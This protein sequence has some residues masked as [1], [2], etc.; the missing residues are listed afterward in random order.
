MLQCNNVPEYGHHSRFNCWLTSDDLY[1]GS[2]RKRI[3][4]VTSHNFRISSTLILKPGNNNLC[5][6]PQLS[7]LFVELEAK[8]VWYMARLVAKNG[9]HSRHVL[10]CN[11]TMCPNMDAIVDTCYDAIG[12][13]ARIWTQFG[14]PI[15]WFKQKENVHFTSHNFCNSSTLILKPWNDNLCDRNCQ[16]CMQ[17]WKQRLC[18]IW[19]G[20]LLF[21]DVPEYGYHSRFSI[22]TIRRERE[23]SLAPIMTFASHQLWSWNLKRQSSWNIALFK[24]V[25]GVGGKGC[26]VFGKAC[27]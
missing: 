6:S 11:W 19:Q 17:G 20:L 18:D 22:N 26:V 4:T 24:I 27:C 15:W 13:C 3:F 23:S 8:D 21:D 2:N 1:D 5:D 10:R 7:K 9:Q 25:C 14:W 12:Q 16:N